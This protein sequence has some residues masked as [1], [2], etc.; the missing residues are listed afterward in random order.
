MRRMIQIRDFNYYSMVSVFV[1]MENLLLFWE[2]W[3]SV[4]MLLEE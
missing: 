4:T 1:A 2:V 3:L